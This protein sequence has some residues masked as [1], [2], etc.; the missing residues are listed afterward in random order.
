M[1][2]LKRLW[3]DKDERNLLKHIGL[4]FIVKGLSLLVSFFSMPLYIKYFDNNDVLGVWYTVLSLLSWINICD[5]GLGNGLRNRLTEN[6]S[7]G[8][9][10]AAKRNI[11]STYVLLLFAIIPI[12]IIG[13]IVLLFVDVNGFFGISQAV[14]DAKTMRLS[15]MILFD[16][17]IIHFV[18]KTINSIIYAIDRKSVV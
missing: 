12:M 15:M 16:G 4:A 17:V 5:L 13:S 9:Y 10:E 3:Q 7:K 2:K 1:N 18:L 8:D 11:S 14:I 6:L